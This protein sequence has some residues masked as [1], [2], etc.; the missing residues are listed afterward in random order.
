MSEEFGARVR[1]FAAIE[2]GS[3]FWGDQVRVNGPLAVVDRLLA[4]G[5]HGEKNS[6]AKIADRLRGTSVDA[7]L[8]HIA[9]ADSYFI[10]PTDA[11]WPSGLNDLAAPPLG[12]IAK[13]ARENL[14][15]LGES[16]AIVGTR[17]PTSYGVRVA[18]EL[19]AGIVD[20]EWSVVSGGAYGIDA[21][22]HKGAIVAEGVTIAVLACGTHVKYPAANE[23]LFEVI[24]ETGLL[25]SEVM[26]SVPAMPSRF[27]IRNRL[28]AALSR[29]TVVVEAA[30]RSGS[31][32]TARDAAEIFR[33]VMAIPGLITS[34]TSEGCHRLVAERCA[35][36]VSSVSEIFAQV[37]LL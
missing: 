15:K 31:L 1:L 33:P 25:L 6:A 16:I 9:A 23:K 30:Y 21:A 20:R 17:N 5:Y 19:A 14:E 11:Y 12:L 27:L 35:E 18:G 36:L 24:E 7:A 4:G 10:A 3:V 8:A 29:G 37:T 2:G 13:G 22:A 28:I 26:P 32:R 34:P